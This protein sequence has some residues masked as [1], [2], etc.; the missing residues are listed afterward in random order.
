MGKKWI[1][2]VVSMVL[3]CAMAVNLT[4]CAAKVHAAD[5]MDGVKANTVAGK[6]P[7]NTFLCTQMDLAVELF[8][9]SVTVSGEGNVLISPLSI[10]LALAMAANGADGQT[11][12]EM[13]RFLG[14][15]ISLETLNEYLFSTVIV[16]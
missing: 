9:S 5:L 10:Q 13:E 8:Q 7:D 11:R 14:G 12:E 2:A 4:G 1:L 6:D 3:V 15:G 16:H